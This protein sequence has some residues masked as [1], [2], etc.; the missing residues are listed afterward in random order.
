MKSM[1]F[2]AFYEYGRFFALWRQL[3][4]FRRQRNRVLRSRVP[5]LSEPPV[6][7]LLRL[8]QA[9]NLNCGMCYQKHK[10]LENEL[11]VQDMERLVKDVSRWRPY[12]YLWG[13]EPLL[14]SD[15]LDTLELLRTHRF[16]TF[17]NTNGLLLSDYAKE[18][19][20][21]RV[22]LITVSVDGPPNVHDRIRNREGAWHKTWLGISAVQEE[23]RRRRTRFPLIQINYLITEDN[24]ECLETTLE[25]FTGLGIWRWRYQLPMYVPPGR[26]EA[27]ERLMAKLYN[28]EATSWRTFPQRVGDMDGGSVARRIRNVKRRKPLMRIT[29]EPPLSL[30][31]VSRYFS[32]DWDNGVPAGC[33]VASAFV[34]VMSDGTV[35]GCPDFPDFVVGNLRD[36]NLSD[37]WHDETYSAFRHSVSL[38]RMP[39]CSRCCNLM[40]LQ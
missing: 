27:Y 19:V 31:L 1:E 25:E 18:I 29:V 32:E 26:G 6:G 30:N 22:Q 24:V 20:S 38:K 5:R 16:L 33:A 9:C 14:S 40:K 4:R 28:V 36:R 35:V 17:V 39:I 10:S 2:N 3:S 34:S 11:N 12:F 37:L 15:F 8:T 13:G 7:I 21:N 23:K